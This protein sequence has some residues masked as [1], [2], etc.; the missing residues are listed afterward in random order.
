MRRTELSGE[1]ARAVSAALWSVLLVL[2]SPGPCGSVA[3]ADEGR[4]TAAR[5]RP[6]LEV[7]VDTDEVDLERGQ[8]TVRMSRPASRVT[9]KVVGA[10]G[11]VLGEVDQKFESAPAGSPLMLRW[12]PPAAHVARIEVYGYDNEGYYKGVA[13]TPWSFEIPHQDVVFDTDSAEIR[14]AEGEKLRATL[15]LIKK[16]LPGARGL[17]QVTLFILAHTDTVGTAEYNVRL[18][19]R[20]AQ[21]IAR[22]FREHGLTIPIAYDGVGERAPKIKTLDEVDEPRNRRADYMLA[23]DAPRFKASGAAPSWKRF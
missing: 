23:I 6:A 7:S 14:P 13:I 12:S 3:R 8:L 18:S 1:L 16:E 2:C 17:G 5:K 19:T 11:A 9:L 4:S 20:R 21:S 15:G 10:S 22:W